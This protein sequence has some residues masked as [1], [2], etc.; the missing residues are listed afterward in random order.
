MAIRP[1]FV[2]ITEP[3]YFKEVEVEFDY[4]NGFALIQ[5]QASIRSLHQAFLK[6]NPDA[7]VLEVSTKSE[8]PL[9]A[10]L[11]AFNLMFYSDV[12]NGSFHIENI[13]QSSKVFEFGGPY[14]D[15]LYVSPKDAKTDDR[16]K[17]SGRLL[18]F[19][20]ACEKWPLEPKTM[21]YD[22]ININ[23]LKQNETLT[24]EIMSYDAFTDIEFNPKKSINCQARSAAM[25]VGL[26]KANQLDKALKTSAGMM[27]VYNEGQQNTEQLS[28]L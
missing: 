24:N 11:S 22:W 23:A 20:Y 16:L 17:T 2:S 27:T 26:K 18:E 8:N 3:P 15:L 19:D 14:R 4:H 10:R 6:R 1:V 25:F 5:K 21:F 12:Y 7:T 9:G 28:F 13:F